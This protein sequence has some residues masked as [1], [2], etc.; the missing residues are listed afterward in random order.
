MSFS[1]DVTLSWKL[2]RI[3]ER[4]V[5]EHLH[6]GEAGMDGDDGREG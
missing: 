4:G 5:C 3:K 6:E 2:V 1:E